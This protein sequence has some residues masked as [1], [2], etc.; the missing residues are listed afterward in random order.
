MLASRKSSAFFSFPS[1][2]SEKSSS[3]KG[4]KKHQCEKY[5]P[6]NNPKTISV[7]L[8]ENRNLREIEPIPIV[9]GQRINSE[10]P[11]PVPYPVKHTLEINQ[12]HPMNVPCKQ[13]TRQYSSVKYSLDNSSGESYTT[14]DIDSVISKSSYT[15]RSQSTSS[16]D[17]ALKYLGDGVQSEFLTDIMINVDKNL[18]KKGLTPKNS[19]ISILNK[20]SQKYF[21][22]FEQFNDFFLL[23]LEYFWKNF[24]IWNK[25]NHKIRL[26]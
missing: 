5:N 10:L 3:T 12:Y 23:W 6:T 9:P 19:F 21:K 4:S 11:F 18:N 16:F 14:L 13:V 8:R 1:S 2:D 20:P 25:E 22:V 26:L 15:S 17:M 24:F 7:Q